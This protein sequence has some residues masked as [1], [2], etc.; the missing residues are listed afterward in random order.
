MDMIEQVTVQERENPTLKLQETPQFLRAREKKEKM[1][2]SVRDTEG[3]GVHLMSHHIKCLDPPPHPLPSNFLK[4]DP[5]RKNITFFFVLCLACALLS[6]GPST[7]VF[8]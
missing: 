3:E 5:S 4:Y 6:C 7:P 2:D 1:K 8:H